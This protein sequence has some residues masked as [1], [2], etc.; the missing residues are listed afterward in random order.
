MS[1][2]RD[3]FRRQDELREYRRQ[4]ERRDDQRRQQWLE[5]E[6]RADWEREDREHEARQREANHRRAIEEMRRGNTAWALNYMIGPDAAINYLNTM[7]QARD[8]DTD[9]ASDVEERD[10]PATEPSWP[11]HT[12]VT[13]TDELLANVATTPFGITLRAARIDAD[14]DGVVEAV[15]TI[16]PGMAALW[17]A[18]GLTEPDDDPGRFWVKSDLL[19]S[20]SGIA[21]T[22]RRGAELT[23]ELEQLGSEH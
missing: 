21:A 6:R 2:D 18:A 1:D 14:G 4:D 20:I 17:R 15:R 13:T 3:Y 16:Y 22:L 23:A 12:F 8:D 19:V 10:S 9:D 11:P 5:D 7:S